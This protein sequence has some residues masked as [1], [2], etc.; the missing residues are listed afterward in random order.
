VLLREFLKLPPDYQLNIVMIKSAQLLLSNV[1][2]HVADNMYELE[3]I[4]GEQADD[5]KEL[6]QNCAAAAFPEKFAIQKH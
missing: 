3:G 5:L 1:L 2:C 6:T 4:I